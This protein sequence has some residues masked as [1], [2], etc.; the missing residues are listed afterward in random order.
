VARDV[1]QPGLSTSRERDAQGVGPGPVTAS[2]LAHIVLRLDL[3]A[4]TRVDGPLQRGE[5]SGEQVVELIDVDL[6]VLEQLAKVPIVLRS[7]VDEWLLVVRGFSAVVRD[8]R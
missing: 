1:D 5:L 2:L 3:D 8:D 6:A 7:S 4:A